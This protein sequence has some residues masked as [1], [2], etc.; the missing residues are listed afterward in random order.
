MTPHV[1]QFPKI[2]ETASPIDAGLI[3]TSWKVAHPLERIAQIIAPRNTAVGP[4]FV[5]H[6]QLFRLNR[7]DFD[8]RMEALEKELALWEKTSADRF[9]AIEKRVEAVTART[10]SVNAQISQYSDRIDQIEKQAAAI[11]KRVSRLEVP[12]K[13]EMLVKRARLIPNPGPVSTFEME[14]IPGPWAWRDL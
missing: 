6:A 4:I 8:A 11:E 2:M 13:K 12:A 1:P 9:D 10:A 14:T 7:M 3:C 5:G